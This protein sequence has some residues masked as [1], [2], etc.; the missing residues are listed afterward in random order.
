MSAQPAVRIWNAPASYD[1]GG[2]LRV[3]RRGPYDPCFRAEGGAVWRGTRTPAGPATLR[4]TAGGRLEP[5][6]PADPAEASGC[7]GGSAG[8]VPVRAEAWGPGGDWCLERLPSLLGADDDP[9]AFVPHHRLTREAHRRHPGL[10]LARTGLVMEA[11]IPSV[12]EQK[13]TTHEA[14]R[15]WRLLVRRYGERAPGPHDDLYVMPDARG[16]C[17]VPSWEWHR[18]GV[19]DKRSA[20]VVRAAQ[21]APRLEEAASMELAAAMRRLQLIP[22]IGPWTAAETLQRSNGDPDALTVGDL[23][24]PRIVGYSLTGARDTD[25]AAML[26]LLAPY[27]GQRHR[28]ARLILLAGR[29]PA[30]R[31]P[32]FPIGN[33]ARL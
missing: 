28:A 10:R 17:R 16:W 2:S 4:I 14:Y 7:A 11:L 9:S 30:R 33:I 24:L 1:L 21:R 6:D 13:V 29:A 8:S 5:A 20:T 31:E 15:A 26:E 12:L 25:D 22:G 27:E 3:L 32:R 23:H 19:D 18:A